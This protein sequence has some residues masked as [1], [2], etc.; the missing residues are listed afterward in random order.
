MMHNR[1]IIRTG[2]YTELFRAGAWDDQVYVEPLKPIDEF[3]KFPN[4]Q[5]F[6]R[7]D[8][9]YEKKGDDFLQ[10]LRITIEIR[11]KRDNNADLNDR[12]NK[13]AAD[14]DAYCEQVEGIVAGIYQK[15]AI[16]LDGNR[17]LIEGILEINSKI[18]PILTGNA[19]YL[20]AEIEFDVRYRQ[21]YCRILP[22]FCEWQKTIGQL[23]PVV[24]NEK[25]VG[26]NANDSYNNPSLGNCL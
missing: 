7:D 26:I 8:R 12:A 10:S 3:A 17:V 9:T 5:I 25:T 20:L 21:G 23:T 24:C 22:N 15:G 2:I 18:T 19:P 4:I 16:E 6:A 14:L 13:L 1:T 11:A